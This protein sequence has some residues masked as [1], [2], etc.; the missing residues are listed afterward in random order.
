MTGSLRIMIFNREGIAGK[1][2]Y[3]LIGNAEPVALDERRG[4]VARTVAAKCGCQT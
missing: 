4:P 1:L 3:I 2:E